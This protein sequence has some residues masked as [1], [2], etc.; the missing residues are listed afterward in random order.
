M[1]ELQNCGSVVDNSCERKCVTDFC[2]QPF[3]K[4]LRR[5]RR[6][7]SVQGDQIPQRRRRVELSDA[8]LHRR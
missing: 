7:I 6:L 5:S 8:P 1:R 3:R 4:R 2:L